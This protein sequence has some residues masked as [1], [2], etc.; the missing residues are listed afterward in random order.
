MNKKKAMIIVIA[1]VMVIV[2]VT[3]AINVVGL[4]RAERSLQDISFSYS[5]AE[6]NVDR[7]VDMQDYCNTYNVEDKNESLDIIS[8]YYSMNEDD[9][10]NFLD[11]S[12]NYVI[13][14]SYVVVKDGS[15]VG[16]YGV[17]VN[18][19]GVDG[20]WVDQRT[21]SFFT[22]S[23]EP[24]EIYDATIELMIDTSIIP[25]E[26]INIVL[27]DNPLQ[28]DYIYDWGMFKERYTKTI[29]VFE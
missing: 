8:S 1:A 26:K 24:G 14:D 22:L 29:G 16:L 27:K 9:A 3:V 4:N 20:I 28:I 15:R 6:K 19:N 23:M 18:T 7:S 17:N 13:Y 21:L 5:T 11:R 2:I 10:R 25:E 12:K